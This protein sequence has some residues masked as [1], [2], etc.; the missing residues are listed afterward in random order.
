MTRALANWAAPAFISARGGRGRHPGPSPGLELAG[1]EPRHRRRRAGR[2]ASPATPWRR[3][4]T[5][6]G[7]PMAT[8]IAAR[9]AGGRSASAPASSRAASARA[10]SSA[11]RAMMSPRSSTTG[12]TS[13]N[14]CCRGSAAPIPDH[15]FD[16]TRALTDGGAAADAVRQPL[17]LDGAARGAIRKCRA[18]RLVRGADRPHVGAHLFRVQAR[19]PARVDP[20]DRRL[21]APAAVGEHVEA[22]RRLRVAELLGL[23]VPGPCLAHVGLDAAYAETGEHARIV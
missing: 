14:R 8:S 1:A 6:P 10:R 2:A 11:T 4:S 12:A 20:A 19:R 5:C 13:R 17:L 22:A 21:L 16:L 9:S 18:A 23:L 7:S 15:Q 3:G